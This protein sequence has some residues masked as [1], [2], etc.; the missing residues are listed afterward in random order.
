M[1]T[2]IL[3]LYFFIRKNFIDTIEYYY[4]RIRG[5]SYSDYYSSRMNRIVT[6]NPNW[7]LNLGKEFHLNLEQK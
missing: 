5:K 6:E 7:G 4:F 3:K 1:K 2:L